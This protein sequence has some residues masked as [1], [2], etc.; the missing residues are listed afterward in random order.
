MLRCVVCHNE[1]PVK[2]YEIDEPIITIGRLPENT[3]SIANMGVSRRHVRIDRDVNR[4][5]ILSD[6][7]S[8]NGTFVNNKKVKKVP[9]SA[10]DKITIGKYTIEIEQILSD[11]PAVA[12]APQAPA[13][14]DAVSPPAPAQAPAPPQQ[15]LPQ[16]EVQAQGKPAT[17]VLIDT[18]KHTVYPIEKRVMSL[19]A[20]ESDDIFISG[21]GIGDTH[22][23]L[24]NRDGSIWLSSSKRS[25]KFKVNGK[26]CLNHKLKHKDRLEIGGSF[27]AYK[28]NG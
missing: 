12:V 27:F 10:G 18:S 4:N 7:G 9:L 25:R 1:E 6:L 22:L 13:Q 16:P 5:Y 24:E 8:L 21:F 26:K 14:Q 23:L 28:E 11:E 17:P 3:I 19:G 20:S 2:T 15:P